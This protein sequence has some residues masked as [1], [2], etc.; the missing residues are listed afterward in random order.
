MLWLNQNIK[1]HSILF[2]NIL[3]FQI[4]MCLSKLLE[5]NR[6]FTMIFEYDSL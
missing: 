4:V 3:I 6:K 5:I 2:F 1:K